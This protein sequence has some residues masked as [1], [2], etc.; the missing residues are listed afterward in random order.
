MITYKIIHSTIPHFLNIEMP[1][2]FSN[3]KVGDLINI[4]GQS[5]NITQ[6]GEVVVG[7]ANNDHIMVFQN[8]NNNQEIKE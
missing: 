6:L 5:M 1:F 2:D 4:L 3:N 8:T 7:C